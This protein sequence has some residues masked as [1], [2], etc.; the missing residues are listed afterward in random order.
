MSVAALVTAM[1]EDQQSAMWMQRP[2]PSPLLHYAAHDI[3]LI[4]LV[5]ER[6]RPGE[7]GNYLARLPRLL[8]MSARYMLVYPS[9]ELRALHVPLDLCRF[10]P[11]DILKAP[12]AWTLRYRCARCVRMLSPGCFA[13]THMEV[14]PVGGDA[15][16]SRSQR[17]VRFSLCRLCNLL[18]R[19]N[20]EMIVGEWFEL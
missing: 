9:R 6:F 5:L 11:L 17:P 3:E 15:S 2:L 1:H 4:A 7:Q 12:P 18:S 10:L 20:G 16:S 13:T 8:E 19:R 14:W